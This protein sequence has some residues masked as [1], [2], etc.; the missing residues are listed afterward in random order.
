MCRTRKGF[1]L[2]G[3]NISF[4]RKK[5]VSFFFFLKEYDVGKEIEECRIKIIYEAPT[6]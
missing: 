2:S 6:P 4:E 3:S 1:P 5:I